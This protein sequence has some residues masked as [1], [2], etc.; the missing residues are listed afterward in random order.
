MQETGD[1]GIVLDAQPHQC[2]DTEFGSQ[3]VTFLGL[4]ALF[5][6]EQGIEVFHEIREDVQENRIKI[7]DEILEVVGRI[8]LL[9]DELRQIGYASVAGNPVQSLIQRILFLDVFRAYIKQQ[10]DIFFLD[11]LL[12]L[13]LLIHGHQIV[14]QFPQ[15]L[16][17][18]L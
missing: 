5:R 15:V 12:L 9:A 10:A 2:I 11:V 7:M 8:L 4:D 13:Y 1:F 6:P 18:A 3:Q 17:L 16:V 14:R